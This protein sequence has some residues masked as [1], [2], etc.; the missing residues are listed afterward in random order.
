MI[1]RKR[2]GE[3]RCNAPAPKPVALVGPKRSGR[4]HLP[5]LN[6]KMRLQDPEEEQRAVAAIRLLLAAITRE[7]LDRRREENRS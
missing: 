5:R 1:E 3:S 4:K 2:D 6:I 7:Y